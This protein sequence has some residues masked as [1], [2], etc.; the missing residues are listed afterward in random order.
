MSAMAGDSSRCS[1]SLTTVCWG[2]PL[3]VPTEATAGR[4]AAARARAVDE[5]GSS[6]YLTLPRKSEGDGQEETW[7]GRLRRG[8]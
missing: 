4:G 6:G 3:R 1:P 2:C 8:E 7:L 5:C